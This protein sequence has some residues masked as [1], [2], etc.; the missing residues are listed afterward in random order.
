MVSLLEEIVGLGA[1]RGLS[2]HRSSPRG[3]DRLVLEFRDA[4]GGVVAGQWYRDPALGASVARRTTDAAGTEHV[5]AL[6]LT[7]GTLLVQRRGADRRLPALQGLARKPGAMLV[8]HRAETRAVVRLTRG[9]YAK[10]VTTEKLASVAAAGAAPAATTALA[11]PRLV[12]VDRHRAVVTTAA[13]PGRTLEARIADRSLSDAALAADAAAVGVA[14][15]EF[16][17][18]PPAAEAP[19]RHDAANEVTVTERW[20]R[21][22]TRFGLLDVEQWNP[23]LTRAAGLLEGTP[24][25]IVRVHRDLHDKQLMIEPGH[26]VGLLDLDLSTTGEAAVDIANLLVHLELRHL[27]GRCSQERA[28]RCGTAFVTAY[29]PDQ[30]TLARVRA[31]QQTT[32]LRLAGVYAF[33]DTPCGVVDHLARGCEEGVPT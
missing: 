8:S 1:A 20:L 4:A 31:Y 17:H 28:D 29:A 26:P 14:L 6:S 19:P 21:A 15:R 11:L 22:A 27:L 7:E 12:G 13:L 30:R 24:S 33:R 2:L 18:L 23:A 25:P 5:S 3:T 10:V 16:H 9:E 32:R